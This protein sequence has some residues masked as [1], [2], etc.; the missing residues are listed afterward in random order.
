[1]KK[2]PFILLLACIMAVLCLPVLAC[3]KPEEPYTDT[4]KLEMVLWQNKG[5]RVVSLGEETSTDI[6]IPATYKGKPVFQIG[7]EAF[8]INN[9]R[10][11]DIS[12]TS[13]VIPQSVTFIG[14]KA[15]EG[16]SLTDVVIPRSV[17]E[18]HQEVF[19]GIETLET[20][21]FEKTD[22][23]KWLPSGDDATKNA[24]LITKSFTDP[25]EAAYLMSNVDEAWINGGYEYAEDRFIEPETYAGVWLLKNV[26]SHSGSTGGSSSGGSSGESVA[27]SNVEYL[28]SGIGE[29]A[30]YVVKSLGNETSTDIVIPAIHNGKVVK[31]IGDQAFSVDNPA[32]KGVRI[33]SIS[34]P[35]SITQIGRN[36]FYGASLSSIVLPA[37]LYIIKPG[38]FLGNPLTSAEF[39]QT[40]H[41]QYRLD[42]AGSRRLGLPA[43]LN[44]SDKG[45][46]ANLL[47]TSHP[48][49]KNVTDSG[50]PT[51][52]GNFLLNIEARYVYED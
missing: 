51:G 13:V 8:S 26:S 9:D 34:L 48:G 7:P 39:K 30:F 25:R 31:H 41:W 27:G 21:H 2:K 38:A 28:L 11:N 46:A 33:T 35:T 14:N 37:S 45:I 36:A 42:Q 4:T 17:L 29:S 19:C 6:V 24:E 40:A 3:K 49:W 52:F 12:I 15:F 10:N 23:W 1:M 18:I 22:E 43:A 32:N 44:I 20:I 50:Y 47:S 16:T 5:Y